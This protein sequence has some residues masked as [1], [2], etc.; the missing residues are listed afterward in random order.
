MFSLPADDYTLRLTI[1]SA[2][3]LVSII[4]LNLLHRLHASLQC[5][6]A[7]APVMNMPGVRGNHKAL[8]SNRKTN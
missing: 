5:E 2:Y 1:A 3:E 7:D 8:P 4:L 6:A